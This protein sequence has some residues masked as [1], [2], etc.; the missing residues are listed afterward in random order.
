MN[1][2]KWKTYTGERVLTHGEIESML[3]DFMMGEDRS[4]I[5]KILMVESTYMKEIEKLQGSELSK[6]CK[7][8]DKWI[9]ELLIEIEKLE[10]ELL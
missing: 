5:H 10:G 7:A 8:K 2:D 3:Q 9:N 4:I 1:D 6:Q